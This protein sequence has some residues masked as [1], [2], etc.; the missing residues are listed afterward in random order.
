MSPKLHTFSFI[1]VVHTSHHQNLFYNRSCFLTVSSQ[2]FNSHKT[3]TPLSIWLISLCLFPSTTRHAHTHLFP[4]SISY[5]KIIIIIY[6]SVDLNI[7]F[8]TARFRTTNFPYF[9]FTLLPLIL[10]VYALYSAL[11]TIYWGYRS[12]FL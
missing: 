8:Y 6:E 1:C 3:T 11:Q 7:C 5:Q 4:V 10:Q 9:S 12:F 2:S